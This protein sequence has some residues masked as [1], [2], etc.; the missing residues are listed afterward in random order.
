MGKI[1][2]RV[3]GYEDIEKKQKEEQKRRSA[4]KKSTKK[5]GKQKIRA[6]GLKGG[7]RMTQVEVSDEAVKKMEKAK[8]ILEEKSDSA[9]AQLGR[10]KAKK[11][12]KKV[13]GINYKKAKKQV[14]RIKEL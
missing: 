10:K 13:R 2:T 4:D 7:E 14:L 6:Q 1:R 11:L 3:L 8:K 12:K 5:A 9:E